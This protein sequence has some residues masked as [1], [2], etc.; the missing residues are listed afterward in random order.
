MSALD[1]LLEGV[2]RK[3]SLGDF[4]ESAADYLAGGERNTFGRKDAPEDIPATYVDSDKEGNT[5]A[6][7]TPGQTMSRKPYEQAKKNSPLA[8]GIGNMIGSATAQLPAFGVTGGIGSL[9]GRLL[10]NYLVGAGEHALSEEQ[11]GLG[12]KL[13]G[14]AK[15][16]VDHPIQTAVNTLLPEA[17]PTILKGAKAGI[18]K[19]LGRAPKE[20]PPGGGGGGGD[21]AEV[22]DIMREISDYESTHGAQESPES[23]AALV[24]KIMDRRI[25]ANDNADVDLPH[26]GKPD[27]VNI[28][29]D[30]INIG[31]PQVPRE[32]RVKRAANDDADRPRIEGETAEEILSSF[33]DAIKKMPMFKPRT[34]KTQGILNEMNETGKLPRKEQLPELVKDA[35]P[36][37]GMIKMRTRKALDEAPVNT[38]NDHMGAYEMGMERSRAASD[39]M[40]NATTYEEKM[41]ALEQQSQAHNLPKREPTGNDDV[42]NMIRELRGKEA[43][44]K[45][46]WEDKWRSKQEDRNLLDPEDE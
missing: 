45:A 15:W 6:G 46:A 38:Q 37:S 27:R 7:L 35:Y 17:L 28:A 20:T 34:P 9:P 22:D 11:G 26:V 30:N 18:G 36:D 10:R 42:S 16:S 41:A 19:L 33:F 44:E 5:L 24:K 29:N 3:A 12:D 13:K 4:G 39:A 25:S 31:M 32:Q 21:P 23:K 14:T 8:T 43:A 1:D 40:D 2:K